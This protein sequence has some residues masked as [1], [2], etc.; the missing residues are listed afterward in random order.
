MSSYMNMI[1]GDIQFVM[2]SKL[3]LGR[4]IENLIIAYYSIFELTNVD[5]SWRYLLDI[6][7]PAF[8][9]KI[10]YYFSL[11]D[12]SVGRSY[13]DIKDI[14]LNAAGYAGTPPP[15]AWYQIY[16]HFINLP[17]F[18]TRLDTYTGEI[19]H[20]P[21][22]LLMEIYFDKYRSSELVKT[23][24]TTYVPVSFCI[25]AYLFNYSIFEWFIKKFGLSNWSRSVVRE[26]FAGSEVLIN[27]SQ[28][29]YEFWDTKIDVQTMLT[30]MN[31][32]VSRLIDIV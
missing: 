3:K 23:I 27:L 28:Q 14:D 7:L 17:H 16:E 25:V 10:L 31:N 13:F 15:I 24:Y 6:N 19:P 18:I 21:I 5:R 4:D 26:K 12:T 20:H 30:D 32:D 1:P 22:L 8:Q 11:I 2:I 29:T 9:S